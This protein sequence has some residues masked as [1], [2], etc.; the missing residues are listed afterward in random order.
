MYYMEYWWVPSAAA[1]L[2]AVIIIV[3]TNFNKSYNRFPINTMLD[4]L[5]DMSR[6]TEADM[7]DLASEL[8]IWRDIY[9]ELSGVKTPSILVEEEK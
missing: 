7:D 6:D 2:L 9:N 8:K 3:K 4:I 5:E 1:V